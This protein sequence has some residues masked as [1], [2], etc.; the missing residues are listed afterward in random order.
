MAECKG[1]KA[2]LSGS[3]QLSQCYDYKAGRY[4]G[5]KD[6]YFIGKENWVECYCCIC[7]PKAVLELA[8][9]FNQ[10]DTILQMYVRG[11]TVTNLV[12]ELRAAI[13]WLT[14]LT[15][16]HKNQQI[17]NANKITTLQKQQI[18]DTNEIITLQKQQIV[19]TNE[20]TTL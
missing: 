18:V 11:A 8:L 20:I 13:T 9:T 16:N 2:A 19:D 1:C 6:G 14:Q 10:E 7:Y 12:F 3:W 5:I 15:E 17:A 4:L